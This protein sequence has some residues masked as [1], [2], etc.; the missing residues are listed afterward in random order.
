MPLGPP[1]GRLLRGAGVAQAQG[2]FLN[3]THFDWITKE[4]HYGQQISKMLGGTHF[5][6]QHRRERPRTAAAQESG[7][8]R[9]RGAVQSARPRS[10]SAEPRNDVAQ[11]T[12]Y[13]DADGLLWF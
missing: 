13:A 1:S 12:D 6:D 11:Q 10:R 7:Q 8:A 9:Q 3:S 4:L 2:F 5:L